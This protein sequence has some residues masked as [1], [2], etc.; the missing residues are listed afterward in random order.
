M[1]GGDLGCVLPFERAELTSGTVGECR[2]S[3][4]A[5]RKQGVVALQTRFCILPFA[6]GLAQKS[7]AKPQA[8]G[9][10][11]K[12]KTAL[13]GLQECD[14]PLETLGFLVGGAGVELIDRAGAGGA[15]ADGAGVAE[16]D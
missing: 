9:T 14:E 5:Q 1:P 15:F 16:H 2:A 8:N 10:D 13:I 7:C 12:R 3:T 11:Q 6:C 4:R